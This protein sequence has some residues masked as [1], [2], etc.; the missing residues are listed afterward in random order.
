MNA[1]AKFSL[2]GADVAQG[3]EQVRPESVH[4]VSGRPL[5][6]ESFVCDHT[7]SSTYADVNRGRHHPQSDFQPSG[8]GETVLRVHDPGPMTRAKGR[9]FL[10][11][12]FKRPRNISC[13]H[14]ILG[15]RRTRFLDAVG[16]ASEFKKPAT[17]E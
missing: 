9:L 7:P 8:R 17:Q 11:H 14:E 5:A 3:V 1:G 13:G 4:T 6:R 2:R 10:F 12:S 16:I 15:K